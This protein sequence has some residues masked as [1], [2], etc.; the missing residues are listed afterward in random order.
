MDSG[1][2]RFARFLEDYANFLKSDRKIIDI[3][4]TPKELLEEASR[5][6]AL[7]RVRREGE[8]I[9]IDLN[10]GKAEHWAHFEG[11]IIMLFDKLYRPLKI[12]IEIKDTM[13]SEKV[14]KS[15]GLI[16]SH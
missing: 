9:V 7:S 15:A 5:I 16:P 8:V 6:R 4:L 14:L 1:L 10:K 2:E 13:D 11:E 12:E 3:P